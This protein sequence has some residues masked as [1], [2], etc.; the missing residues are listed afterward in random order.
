MIYLMIVL[1]EDP[2]NRPD[3]I[4]VLN[5]LLELEI[6]YTSKKKIVDLFCIYLIFSTV[7]IKKYNIYINKEII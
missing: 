2:N 1:N 5:R 7:E 4:H 3:I 6:F